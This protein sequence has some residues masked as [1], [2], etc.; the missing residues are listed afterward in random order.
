MNILIIATRYP[1]K[2]NMEFV[3]VKKLVNEWAKM[4][5]KCVVM[6]CFSWSTW[7]RG[8]RRYVP[9]H[10]TDHTCQENPVEVYNPRHVS[11][12]SLKINGVDASL[13]F[14]VRVLERRFRKTG[15]KPNFIYCHFFEEGVRG[16]YLSRKYN[17]PFFVASGECNI[18]PVGVPAKG[19]NPSQ[20]KEDIAG[21]VCVSSKNRNEAVSMGLVED[22]QCKVFPNGT[23]TSIFRR[24][25]KAKCRRDLGLEQ[26]SFI[27]ICVGYFCKRKGQDRLLEAIRKIGNKNIKVVFLGNA[28]KI[29]TFPLEGEEI[30]FKGSVENTRMPVYMNAADVFCLPTLAEGCCNAVI[31]ALACGLPIVSSNLPFN[32]DVLDESNSIMVNPESVDEIAKAIAVLYDDKDKRNALAEGALRRS[33]TLAIKQR[34]EGIL[35]FIKDRL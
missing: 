10:Y 31:E 28:A 25:D 34:A 19:Y 3:F 13:A 29:D 12:P 5:H 6:T 24:I 7:I 27:V 21:C 8:R 9:L 18:P 20:L 26:D 15:F 35:Q 4:G 22:K 2:D 14:S 33:E 30:L 16:W 23:D 17:I 11:F 1:Y 32:W